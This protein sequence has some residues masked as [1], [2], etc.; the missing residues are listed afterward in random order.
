LNIQ[1][2]PNPSNGVFNLT[3]NTSVNGQIVVTDAT[4]RIIATQS[5]SGTS[6]TID[7]TNSVTGIYYFTIQ[8]NDSEKVIKNAQLWFEKINQ[9]SPKLA[10]ERIW[11]AIAK[12]IDKD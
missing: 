1:V 4:G 5:M 10:S 6:S 8:F 9:H 11:D 3:M 7:L 2:N 12:I